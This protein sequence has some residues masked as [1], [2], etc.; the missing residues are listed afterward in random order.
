MS[1]QSLPR[2]IRNHN[3]G[4]IEK[5][6][7]WQGLAQDQSSDPRFAVFKNPVWGIRALTRLLINYQDRHGLDTVEKMINRWAP[8]VG[9]D[10]TGASYEQNTSSYVRQVSTAMGIQPD[11]SF[12]ITEYSLAYPMVEAI[13]QHENGMQPYSKDQIDEGLRRAGIVPSKSKKEASKTDSAA[14]GA[15]VGAIGAGGAAVATAISDVAN[16]TQEAAGTLLSVSE[17]A[18]YIFL[19]AAMIGAGASAYIVIRRHRQGIDE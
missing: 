15:S 4:N 5:G 8:P 16:T 17:I 3:P 18:Q 14:T 12:D 19:A 7:P 6:D 1:K 2:G 11:Q 9:K 13:I 10:H